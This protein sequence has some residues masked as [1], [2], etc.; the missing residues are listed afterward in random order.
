MSELDE[1]ERAAAAGELERALE[2]AR[3]QDH[4]GAS[5]ASA[6]WARWALLAAQ[7]GDADLAARLAVH[8]EDDGVRT[9]IAEVL[10]PD[11]AVADHPLEDG[12]DDVDVRPLEGGDA[13][14]ALVE[15]FLELFGGR[16][17]IYARQWHDERRGRSGY[18]P[19]REPLTASVARAHLAGRTT[20]G[21][22][23]LWP[24]ATVSCAAVDLDL[25]ASALE[26][27]RAGRGDNA[28]PLAHHG[29]RG[30]ARRLM[31]AGRSLGL[32]LFAEDS[33][34]RGVHLWLFLTP[35]RPARLARQL[36]GQVVAAAG[37]QPADVSVEIFPK[38]DRPGS[39]GLSSLVKLPLGLHQ[40]TL[41]PCPLLD[42]GLDPIDDVAE[43]LARLAP[44]DPSLVD[45]VAGRR[46][47]AL[48]APDL[49][50]AEPPPPLP[51][52]TS[53]RSLAA[54]LRAVEG[55]E[56]RD[57]AERMLGGCPALRALV[58]RAHSERR[59]DPEQAR[60]LTY[61]IGLVGP[62]ELARDVLVAAGASLKELERVRRGLPSPAGCKR[63]CRV[64]GRAEHCTGCPEPGAR[65]YRTP[66]LFA[67]GERR[68]A[69]PRH[70]PFAPWLEAGEEVVASPLERLG[71]ALERIERRLVRIE[72]GDADGGEEEDQEGESE[73]TDGVRGA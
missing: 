49:D 24:D 23:L 40:A 27:L 47:L 46:L 34:N 22:Y 44:A 61:T 14:A 18:R 41:R 53:G 21:Q 50:A 2:L 55:H 20:I 31:D 37:P 57:A 69:P 63:V 7:A 29:L 30:Y 5:C 28:S 62:G 13:D 68:P 71:E 48:P 45:A 43:A 52:V 6:D 66:A 17:D 73:G 9:R 25:A 64:A 36:L 60:V 58:D 26:A 10:G 54:A 4:G 33:G 32:P 39:R 19:V 11:E 67:V 35:R 15:R 65:P 3:R 12:D 59:L 8:V 51:S 70:V 42:D 38:Q 56:A 1:A 16:R 72:Q